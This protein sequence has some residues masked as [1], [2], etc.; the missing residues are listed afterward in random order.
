MAAA[1]AQ[2][3]FE[4]FLASIT[5]TPLQV[6]SLVNQGITSFD[7]LKG[8]SDSEIH[9]MCV[10]IRRQ[11][12]LNP[13]NPAQLLA[14]VTIPIKH[15]HNLKLTAYYIRHLDRTQRAF[16]IDLATVERLE[17][18]QVLKEEEKEAKEKKI[19]PLTK[20]ESVAKIR[21]TLDKH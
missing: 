19:T 9:E 10:I 16:L 18:M 15:E 1:A 5:F 13:A 17:E 3:Q 8:M 21:V 7:V 2:A 14:P 11:P 4:A 12:R 6:E 20:L